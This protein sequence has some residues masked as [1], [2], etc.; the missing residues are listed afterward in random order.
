MVLK[1]LSPH[2]RQAARD[3][4]LHA[5]TRRAAVK[6]DLTEGTLSLSD[7]FELAEHDDAVARMRTID[8]LMSL[9]S[10]GEIRAMAIMEKH[11]IAANRR[12]RGLGKRQREAL[13][14]RFGG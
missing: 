14:L 8:L 6:S 5:R 7:V 11:G 9:R 2:E 3:K 12:L 4:A 10:I 13:I 1:D